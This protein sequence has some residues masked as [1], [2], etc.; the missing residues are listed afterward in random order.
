MRRRSRVLGGA[1]RGRPLST[2]PLIVWPLPG[3]SG[4]RGRPLW[5]RSSGA[6]AVFPAVALGDGVASVLTGHADTPGFL[7]VTGPSA[8][9][10]GRPWASAGP[11]SFAKLLWGIV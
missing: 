2:P 7:P 3:P 5:G 10:P 1:P 8:H 4:L 9:W 11:P 6:F